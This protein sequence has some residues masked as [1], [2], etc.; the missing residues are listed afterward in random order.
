VPNF[1]ILIYGDDDKWG[2]RTEQERAQV[3]DAHRAF[4]AAGSVRASGELES[5]AHSKSIRGI[6]GERVLVTDG[7][8]AEFKEVLGGYY[9]IEAADI[10]QAVARASALY[11]NREPH[12]HVEVWPLVQR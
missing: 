10:D 3:D 12:A 8:F 5:A 6:E 1:L 7:P 4:Q 11:E 9:E 2:E